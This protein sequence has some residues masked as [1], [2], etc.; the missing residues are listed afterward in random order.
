VRRH[1]SLPSRRG[2]AA[3]AGPGRGQS[4]LEHGQ[5][6][7]GLVDLARRLPHGERR[8]LGDSRADVFHRAGAGG[9]QPAA[10]RSFGL[11]RQAAKQLGER[12]SWV[13]HGLSVFPITTWQVLRW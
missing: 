9:E 3:V 1:A 13:R 2:A 5:A 4:E 12:R 10:A 7:H 6:S 8:G 11:G